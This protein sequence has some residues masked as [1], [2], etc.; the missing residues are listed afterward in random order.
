MIAIN[1]SILAPYRMMVIFILLGYLVTICV[2]LPNYIDV[3]SVNTVLG[4]IAII[5]T[6]RGTDTGKRIVGWMIA[7]GAMLLMYAW[8]PSKFFLYTAIGMAVFSLFEMVAGKAGLLSMLCLFLMS[9][10]CEYFA[11]VFGFP[12]RLQLTKMA[13]QI[14]HLMDSGYHSEG[15]ILLKGAT[16]FSVDTACMGLHMLISS[17]IA[18]M[19]LMGMYQRRLKK[20][21][22]IAY[23]MA[24]CIAV[25]ILNLLS[26]LIRIISLVEFQVPP[27]NKM[28]STIGLVC[29]FIYVLLP[30]VMLIRFSVSR[31]GTSHTWQNGN[32]GISQKKISVQ[33]FLMIMIFC[34]AMA[35][36]DRSITQHLPGGKVKAPDYRVEN[37]QDAIVKLSTE[38]GLVYLKPIIGFY[39]SDHQPTMCW[40]GSGYEFRKL[41][42]FILDGQMVYTSS[43]EKGIDK[44]YTAWWYDNGN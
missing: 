30:T 14:L 27:E 6:W 21:L 3:F 19:I 20:K 4:I 38:R 40:K 22:S 28:H 26:N 16:E 35:G 12:F 10:L 32:V 34:I 7:V 42:T 29:F 39:S 13:G 36:K 9:P 33:F 37:L 11:N 5:F 24:I 23:L 43:L 8:I 17:M 31:F 15:N 44:L 2:G 25:F 41:E 1:R 18:G